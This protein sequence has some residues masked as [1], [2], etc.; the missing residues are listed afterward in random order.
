MSMT[1]THIKTERTCATCYKQFF[2]ATSARYCSWQCRQKAA[3]TVGL[4]CLHCGKAF[5]VKPSHRDKRTYCSMK[6][7]G[8][9]KT[10]RMSVTMKC[11]HCGKDF[12]KPPSK[13]AGKFRYCSHQCAYD[14]LAIRRS[15]GGHITE[16][17]YRVLRIKG[18]D[19][20]RR[21]VL[22]HRYVMEKL[23]RRPLEDFEN[24]HHKNGQ[25]ADNRPENLELW[26]TSQPSGQRP[27][28]KD[29]WA[30]AWLESR[31]YVVTKGEGSSAHA[32]VVS[33]P[34]RQS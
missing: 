18:T 9:A 2:G 8:E 7:K 25:R 32:V 13:R 1:G 23:L 10:Q 30:I 24:V 34:P 27:E 16:D 4:N 31:G 22:E 33:P 28:D 21:Y 6:C 26:I 12:R 11:D 17:G 14:H 19:G 3:E 5:T 29:E 15:R 20:K